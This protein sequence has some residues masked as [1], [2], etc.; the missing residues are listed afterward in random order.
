[1]DQWVFC[2]SL[3]PDGRILAGGWFENVAGVARGRVARLNSDGTLDA[4][5]DPGGGANSLIDRIVLEKNG[6]IVIGGNFSTFDHQPRRG[7]VR[8]R[9]E[10][11]ASMK[12]AASVLEK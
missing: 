6:D 10:R 5:F 9:G 3:Q 4:A 7:I 8:L 12:A 11:S 1:M 2:L